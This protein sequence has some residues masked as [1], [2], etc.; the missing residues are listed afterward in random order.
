[1]PGSPLAEQHQQKFTD[2]LKQVKLGLQNW[3]TDRCF[4]KMK[5]YM[6]ATMY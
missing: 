2:K 1:M 5:G 6:T 4:Q 3:K